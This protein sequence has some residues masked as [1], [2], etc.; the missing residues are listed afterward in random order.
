MFNTQIINAIKDMFD[1]NQFILSLPKEEQYQR[2]RYLLSL[3]S[4]DSGIMQRAMNK[5]REY[6]IRE[7]VWTEPLENTI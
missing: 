4:W 2:L 1:L 3:F 7:Y 5:K 6:I